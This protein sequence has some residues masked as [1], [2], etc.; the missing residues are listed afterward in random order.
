MWDDYA[1]IVQD[2]MDLGTVETMLIGGK[3]AFLGQLNDA[4]RLVFHNCQL[5]NNSESAIWAEAATMARCV[6]LCVQ[7]VT[8]FD[9]KARRAVPCT[10]WQ[11]LSDDRPD[12]RLADARR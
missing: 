7:K 11:A 12:G 1:T 2:P 9:Q 8:G 3:F 6:R 10:V 4:I 5:Y